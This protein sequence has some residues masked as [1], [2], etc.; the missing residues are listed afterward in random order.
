MVDLIITMRSDWKVAANGL[1]EGIVDNGNGTATTTWRGQNPM[2]TYL[3][4][5]TAGPYQEIV[6]SAMNVRFPFRTL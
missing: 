5:I 2:T 6:Q 3:V 1:R 4:C